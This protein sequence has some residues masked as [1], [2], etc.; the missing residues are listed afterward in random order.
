MVMD[1]VLTVSCILLGQV[2][3]STGKAYRMGKVAL[4]LLI[5][6]LFANILL[7]ANLYQ[8]SIYSCLA[9]PFPPQTPQSVEDLINWDIPILAMDIFY[10]DPSSTYKSNLL[11]RIIPEL[12]LSEGSSPQFI[13]L[14]KNLHARAL[15]WKNR[16]EKDMVTRIITERLKRKHRMI[17][18]FLSGDWSKYGIKQIQMAGVRRIVRN[19]GASPFMHVQLRTGIS[20]LLSPYVA[21]EWKRMFVFGTTNMWNTLLQESRTLRNKSDLYGERYRDSLQN[22][23]GSPKISDQ[24]HESEPVSVELIRPIFAICAVIMGFCLAGFLVEIR[25][26]VI[27]NVKKRLIHWRKMFKTLLNSWSLKHRKHTV[28]IIR[29]QEL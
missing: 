24:F 26:L 1:K 8:G 21:K 16:S 12:L 18:L 2:G 6:W 3:E 5:L 14:L 13:K 9:V 20:N 17:A 19:K 25:K 29:Q 11:D 23:F 10:D 7:M 15:P 4:V 22:A 28:S 27:L